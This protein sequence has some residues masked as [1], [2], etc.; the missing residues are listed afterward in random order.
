MWELGSVFYAL[1]YID[2]AP[3]AEKLFMEALAMQRRISSD[4]HINIIASQMYLGE[5][6]LVSGGVSGKAETSLLEAQAARKELWRRGN[7]LA[8]GDEGSMY[9]STFDDSNLL[10]LVSIYI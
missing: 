7:D 8:M 2:S 1:A 3:E 4:P 6:Y 5:M 9:H 10:C